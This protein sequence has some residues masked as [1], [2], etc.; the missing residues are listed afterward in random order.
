MQIVNIYSFSL[1]KYANENEIEIFNEIH[2]SVNARF[3]RQSPTH[4]LTQL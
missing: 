4:T 1:L 3:V 2:M